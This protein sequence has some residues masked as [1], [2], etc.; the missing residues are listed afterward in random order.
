M[1][2]FFQMLLSSPDLRERISRNAARHVAETRTPAHSVQ[3]LMILWL[4][5][6]SKSRAIAIFAAPCG[7]TPADW[8]LATQRFPARTGN[9]Q[10]GGRGKPPRARSRILKVSLPA[11]RLLPTATI[12]VSVRRFLF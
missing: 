12:I 7:D 1:P 5:L 8:F 10:D 9:F 2:S 3:D 6:L 4:G 11:T